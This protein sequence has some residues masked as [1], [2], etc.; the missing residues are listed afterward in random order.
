MT[1]LELQHYL[2]IYDIP[3]GKARVREFGGD[4]EAALAAYSEVEREY[5][6]RPDVDIVL[7]GADSLE[8]I[9]R[10]HSS[11]FETQAFESLL[12]PGVLTPA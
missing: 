12:P 3:A 8:V 5:E 7:L 2:V 11:Y 1:D 4:Y 9:K 10:T 6:H